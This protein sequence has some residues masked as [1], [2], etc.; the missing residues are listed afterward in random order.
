MYTDQ[1][2]GLYGDRQ[3]IVLVRAGVVFVPTASGM[4]SLIVIDRENVPH[5]K[6]HMEWQACVVSHGKLVHQQLPA[7]DSHWT[8]NVVMC[9]LH[10]Q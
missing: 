1:M 3:S 10:C 5:R 8:Y 9:W 2:C 6:T 7:L 4:Q